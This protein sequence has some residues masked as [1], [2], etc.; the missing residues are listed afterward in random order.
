M[1]AHDVTPANLTYKA[2]AG[3]RWAYHNIQ[4]YKTGKLAVKAGTPISIPA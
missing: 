4:N 3:T 2:D 1:T